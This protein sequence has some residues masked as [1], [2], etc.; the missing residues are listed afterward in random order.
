MYKNTLV[1]LTFENEEILKW[2]DNFN[3]YEEMDKVFKPKQEHKQTETRTNIY[4]MK[5]R[6]DA[7]EF[8]KTF[9][10]IK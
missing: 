6:T 4:S 7:Q 8:Y 9:K 3:Y 5:T 2:F 1:K 10:K